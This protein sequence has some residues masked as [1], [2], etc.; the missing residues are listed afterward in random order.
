MYPL[1]IQA[2][3]KKIFISYIFASK[4]WRNYCYCLE[5]M[6]QEKTTLVKLMTGIY[7]PTEGDVKIGGIDT[8]K[9]SPQC[10]YNGISGVFQKY[11][12]YKITLK[13]NIIISSMEEKEDEKL[14]ADL[15]TAVSKSDLIIDEKKFPKDM[16]NYALTRI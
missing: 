6:A 10:L 16:K 12:R 4:S 3:I 2:Q 14:K 13:E 8:A 9:I 1:L 7:L 5:K 15:E 11:Q